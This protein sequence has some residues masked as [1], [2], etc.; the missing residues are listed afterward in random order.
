MEKSAVDIIYENACKGKYTQI[1]C[2]SF[3]V[4]LVTG[5]I[6][7]SETFRIGDTYYDYNCDPYDS[8]H[9]IGEYNVE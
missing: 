2:Y 3:T 5:E 4:D 6:K 7:M 9:V 8:W 1:G